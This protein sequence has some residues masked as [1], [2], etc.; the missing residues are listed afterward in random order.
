MAKDL[1]TI[2]ANVA[3]RAVKL[4]QAGEMVMDSTTRMALPPAVKLATDKIREKLAATTIEGED[5][6]GQPV[7][8]TALD[9]VR[10]IFGDSGPTL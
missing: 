1:G 7:T 10:A 3:D 5:A 4:G 2:I 8:Y 6:S 9:L